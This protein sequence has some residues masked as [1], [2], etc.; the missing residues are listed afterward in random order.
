MGRSISKIINSVSR[1][2]HR[3]TVIHGMALHCLF[4]NTMYVPRALC[5]FLVI[6]SNVPRYIACLLFKHLHFF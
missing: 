1:E 6:P 3:M 2:W 5:V 4:S